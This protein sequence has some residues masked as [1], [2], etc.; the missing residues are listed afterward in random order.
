MKTRV[1]FRVAADIAEALKDLPNQTNF[2]ESVLREALA[3][4]CP[5]CG[6][7][8]RVSAVRLRI[9]NIR[10]AGLPPLSREE[11]RYLKELIHL[12]RELAATDVQLSKSQNDSLGFSLTRNDAVLLRGTLDEAGARLRA[13]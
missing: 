10:E 4:T 1:T 11:A 9:S 8:G 12:A 6:G 13:N 5:T 7:S 2:V 3:N